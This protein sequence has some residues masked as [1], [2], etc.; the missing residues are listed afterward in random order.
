MRLVKYFN[1]LYK[2]FHEGG[3]WEF[4]WYVN[5]RF[6]SY[7][8]G[9]ALH[10]KPSF[11][12]DIYGEE[13][14]RSGRVIIPPDQCTHSDWNGCD[15]QGTPDNII[16]PIRSA[17]VTTHNSFHYKFGR[18]EIRAKMPAGDWLWPVILRN[19]V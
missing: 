10:I 8:T 4:Q 1:E 9:G 13:F 5:D 11:T 14:L 7:T 2:L 19:L 6:N 3:N 15:R 16:N 17:I 18:L 12:A